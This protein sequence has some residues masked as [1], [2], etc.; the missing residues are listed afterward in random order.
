MKLFLTF[1]FVRN[2]LANIGER[3]RAT[4]E[5][6]IIAKVK[7]IAVSLNS[8]PDI[9]S[10]KIN[11]KKTATKTNVVEMI[12]KVTLLDPLTDDTQPE[13]K[14]KHVRDSEGWLPFPNHRTPPVPIQY[15]YTQ[16]LFAKILGAFPKPMASPDPR[17]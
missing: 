13:I 5:D 15:L 3:V 2:L 10:I 9:P 14:A 11:G 6:T 12:A 1:F 17:P 16:V 8:V 7:E 4:K